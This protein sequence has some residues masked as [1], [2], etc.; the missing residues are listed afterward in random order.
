MKIICKKIDTLNGI[1]EYKKDWDLLFNQSGSVIAQSYDFSVKSQIYSMSNYKKSTHY[2]LLFFIKD[3]LVCVMPF[4]KIGQSLYKSKG[5]NTDS[6]DFDFLIFSENITKY[7]CKALS[8]HLIELR[9]NLIVNNVRSNSSFI[10]YFQYY[11]K[12]SLCFVDN[13]QII[14]PLV[15]RGTD[16]LSI[17]KKDKYEKR[18]IL[19][20]ISKSSTIL[21]ENISFDTIRKFSNELIKT[22]V[23]SASFLN[24]NLLEYLFHGITN[25]WIKVYETKIGNRL[26]ALNFFIINNDD[27]IIDFIDLYKDIPYLNIGVIHRIID[28]EKNGQYKTIQLGK[29]LYPYKIKN[30]NPSV[31]A[32]ISIYSTNS[33]TIHLGQIIKHIFL[34]LYIY[35]KNN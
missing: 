15:S 35:Y 22:K 7:I 28:M 11:N 12:Y 19:K 21:N 27:S 20:K 31:K 25:K 24:E 10:K 32:L 23:R 5:I 30:F 8:S 6:D 34:K 17:S 16:K 2:F 18:R 33:L 13:E 1:I 4:I 3:K 14:I 26:V 9:L 29:G